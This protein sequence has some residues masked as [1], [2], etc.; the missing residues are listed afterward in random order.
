MPLC[1]VFGGEEGMRRLTRDTCDEIVR[2]PTKPGFASLNVATSFAIAA[3]E[4]ERQR[5]KSRVPACG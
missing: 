5:R 3:Y 1:L 4:V 2:I